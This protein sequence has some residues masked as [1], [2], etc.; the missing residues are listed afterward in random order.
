MKVRGIDIPILPL[1]EVV[2]VVCGGTPNTGVTDYWGGDVLWLTPKEM[3]QLQGPVISSTVRTLTR[4]GLMHS[5]A[6][7]VPANSVILSTR[8]PIGHLAINSTPMAFNQGCRG[9]VVGKQVDYQ[10]LYYYLTVKRKLLESLGDGTTFKELSARKLKL[11]SIPVPPLYIQH[12]I[13]EKLATVYRLL[14]VVKANTATTLDDIQELRR[15]IF[16]KQLRHKCKLPLGEVVADI[17]MGQSPQSSEINLIGDG[18]P[19]HQGKKNFG[20]RYLGPSFKWSTSILRIAL[21]GDILMSVRAPVG[22]VNETKEKICIGRGLAAIRC[23]NLLQ[24]RYIWHVLHI[25]QDDIVGNVGTTFNSIGR[26]GLER[27]E[28]PFLAELE[29]RHIV[30]ALDE[31][32]VNFAS[33]RKNIVANFANISELWHVILE[34]AFD[35]KLT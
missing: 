29:Q 5:S 35:G 4:E 20:E 19:F 8:A 7:L 34:H 30:D 23:K 31:V 16:D 28:V 1:G 11:L 24:R 26:S 33:L 6:T 15:K 22:P 2:K 18:L 17:I 10:Y 3:G 32:E 25:M 27:L 14:A 21:P 9:L 13:V 12:D